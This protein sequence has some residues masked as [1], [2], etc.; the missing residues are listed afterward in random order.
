MVIIIYDHGITSQEKE[1]KRKQFH[2]CTSVSP[3]DA[4][5]IVFFARRQRPDFL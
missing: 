3:P 5:S 4:L 2:G 1:M